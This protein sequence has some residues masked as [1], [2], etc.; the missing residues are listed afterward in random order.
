MWR[1]RR[2][3]CRWAINSRAEKVI[4]RKMSG[5]WIVDRIELAANQEIVFEPGVV[6]LAEKGAFHGK[7]DSL[8]SAGNMANIKLTGPGATLQ[9]RR[10]DYDGKE[11]SKAEW[12]H[13]LNF[14]GCTNVTITG[15]TLAESGGDGIYLGAGTRAGRTRTSSSSP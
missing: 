1:N 4:V 9:M 2:A 13:V 12:R 10:A 8:F 5:P 14:H 15:L 7:S 3:P 11:Y 6:V